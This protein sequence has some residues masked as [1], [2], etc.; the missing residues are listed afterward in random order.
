MR[1]NGAAQKVVREAGMGDWQGVSSHAL[2]TVT[3]NQ[4]HNIGPREN[5]NQ[6]VMSPIRGWGQHSGYI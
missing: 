1:E 5:I 6:L 2:G 3:V 4:V